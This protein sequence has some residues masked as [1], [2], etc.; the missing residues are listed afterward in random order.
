MF[1]GYIA[2]REPYQME[3]LIFCGKFETSMIIW[4]P[5]GLSKSFSTQMRSY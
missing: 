3:A 2:T 4:G 5:R 1:C